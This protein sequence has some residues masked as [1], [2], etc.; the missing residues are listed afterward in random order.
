MFTCARVA[1]EF[2][3]DENDL[4]SLHIYNEEIK[5]QVAREEHLKQE[6]F[7]VAY[8]EEP[9]KLRLVFQPL[10]DLKSGK[11]V[12]FEALARYES[13][14]YGHVSPVEFIPLVEKNRLA[15]GF[16]KKIIDLAIS[17]LQEL[18]HNGIS[19]IPVSVNTSILQLLDPW[20]IES[21][22]R[23]L[24]A[25]HVPPYLFIIELTESVFATNINLLNERLTTLSKH[26]ILTALD[27]FG[28][29][30]SSLALIEK[31]RFS[32]VK[33]DRLFIQNLTREN[34]G[35]TTIPEIIQICHKFG[36]ASLAEGIETIDQYNLL[37]ELGCKY[38]QGFYM[39]RPLKACDAL[40][41]IKQ[42][43]ALV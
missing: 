40:D 32:T 43:K 20:F 30:F 3:S 10:V 25:A 17:F 26:G 37:R 41:F 33:I 15:V 6:L 29:G 7:N 24:N 31:L 12:A 35:M 14:I 18:L 13:D 42:D 39:S 27:D 22:L 28:T 16:G 5:K 8:S 2:A 9:H 1:A 4:F 21:L 38:G 34:M 19:D 23:K 36:L 11:T